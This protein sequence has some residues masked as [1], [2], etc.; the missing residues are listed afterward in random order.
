MIS[1]RFVFI[2]YS[3][4]FH[5]YMFQL[6]KN[7]MIIEKHVKAQK[8][9]KLS[10]TVNFHRFT[11]YLHVI[12]IVCKFSIFSVITWYWERCELSRV[13]EPKCLYEKNLS[14]L[15]GLSYLPRRDNSP[16]RIV[17]PSVTSSRFSCKRFAEFFKVISEKL[18]RPCR[19]TRAE[20]CFGTRNHINGPYK[21]VIMPLCPFS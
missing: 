10:F 1:I 17:S 12:Y 7:Y 5:I 13:G 4:F 3:I 11:C 14:S 16:T 8:S 21:C 6:K 9:C 20:G 19:V 2:I 15:P 18:A